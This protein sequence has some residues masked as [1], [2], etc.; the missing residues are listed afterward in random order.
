VCVIDSGVDYLHED[1]AGNMHPDIGYN[2][3]YYYDG[4]QKNDPMDTDGHGTAVAGVIG[5]VGNNSLGGVGVNWETSIVACK[6]G[7]GDCYIFFMV[8][9]HQYCR[10][11]SSVRVTSMSANTAV[12]S[13]VL[14]A[15]MNASSGILHVCSAGNQATNVDA[16]RDPALLVFPAKFN[17]TNIVSV[18]AFANT[19]DRL[20]PLSTYGSVSVDLAAPGQQI[21]CP[22][23]GNKYSAASGTS[24]AT[25]MVSGAAALIWS[26]KPWLTVDQLKAALLG[27]VT[28]HANLT[29]KVLSGGYLNVA[30]SLST[31]KRVFVT[32]K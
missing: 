31:V 18:A 2:A 27:G 32:K 10:G 26:R 23:P 16:V 13:G 15:A 6:C 21:F 9:C 28:L 5:A 3:Y 14:Y 17:L 19:F 7:P 24:F 29:G 8:K 4:R 11:V 1:L 12:M 22:R 20:W 30:R 25:P